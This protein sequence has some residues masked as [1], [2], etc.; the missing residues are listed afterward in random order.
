MEAK[1]TLMT[2]SSMLLHKWVEHIIFGGHRFYMN[3]TFHKL[4]V[5]HCNQNIFSPYLFTRQHQTNTKN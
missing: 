5:F 4:L 3:A 2:H 1:C